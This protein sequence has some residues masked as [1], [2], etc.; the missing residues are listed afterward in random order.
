MLNGKFY[1]GSATSFE[2]RVWQ[3]KYDL[4]RGVHKNPH[5][6]A[7]WNKYGEVAFVFEIVEQIPLGESQLAWE[8]KHLILHAAKR[9]CYNINQHAE[10]ARL[11]IPHTAGTKEKISASRIGKMTGQDHYRYGKTVSAEVREKIGVAQRGVKKAPRVLTEAGRAKIRAAAAAGHY[12]SFAGKTHTDAAKEKMSRAVV[13]ALPDSTTRR[14]TGLTE[15]RDT[16]GVSIATSI[17]ACK[18]GRPIKYGV[19]A[20]WVMSYEAAAQNEAP[21]IPDEFAQYPRTRTA[22]QAAGAAHYFTGLPCVQGHIAL[23]RTKGVCIECARIDGEKSNEKKRV[24][25]QRAS[26]EQYRCDIARNKERLPPT[27]IAVHKARLVAGL[28]A[29]G[30]K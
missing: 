5:L 7:S 18:T 20:G 13:A 3:H 27:E 29:L 4:R 2:R 22:A 8:E 25:Q 1:I 21:S 24:A 26:L 10:L 17:R 14:F 9:S 12:A 19:C 23:R 28:A 11:G 30:A 6:Q 16:L 15:I